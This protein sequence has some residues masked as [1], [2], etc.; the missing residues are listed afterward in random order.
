MELTYS[1]RGDVAYVKVGGPIIP[2]GNHRKERLDADRFVRYADADDAVLAY[3]FL[4]ARRHGV[5]LDDL[6]HRDELRALFHEAGFAERDWGTPAGAGR[7]RTTR[8][9]RA[10]KGAP[11]T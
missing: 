6:A 8:R 11:A 4:N 10:R 1:E 9:D 2:G 3:E 7:P 5:R